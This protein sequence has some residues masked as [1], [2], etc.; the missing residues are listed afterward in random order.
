MRHFLRVSDRSGDVLQELID[1]AI[2]LAPAFEERRTLDSLSGH[3]IA[4]SWEG[5]GFRNRVAFELGATLLGADVVAVPG[6][7]GEFEAIA[8]VGAY[9][10]NWFDAIVIRTSSFDSLTALAA[11]TESMVVN[12][13]TSHNHPCEILGDLAYLDA[14]GHALGS[15]TRVVFVGAATNLCHSWLEAAA[16][17]PVAVTQVCPPG[18]E[19]DL[20]WWKQLVPHPVGSVD[21]TD[22]LDERVTA[23]HVIY[24]D[25]WPTGLTPRVR[26]QFY[27]LQIT[28]EILDRCGTD[29]RFLPC[30]PVT[31]GEEVS[32]DAMTH[33]RCAVV[34][35]KR[36]LLPAQAALLVRELAPSSSDNSA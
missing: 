19:I 22:R 27:D 23:A 34:D 9:L 5:D 2:Q 24:T 17:L 12:A 30:P 31:R 21:V 7:L 28:A 32:D 36:W 6:A 4:V 13:R 33:P 14:T 1:A 3:R 29:V 15:P 35:A 26:Q 18:F 20:R 25:C 10:G 8:D 16:V 11:S